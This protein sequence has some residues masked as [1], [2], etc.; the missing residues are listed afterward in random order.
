MCLGICSLNKVRHAQVSNRMA[1]TNTESKIC[2]LCEILVW[3]RLLTK[4]FG[5][6]KYLNSLPFIK[7]QPAQH[8][9]LHIFIGLQIWRFANLGDCEINLRHL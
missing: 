4:K 8:R 6:I 9:Y 3:W 1:N 7:G 5:D 2:I